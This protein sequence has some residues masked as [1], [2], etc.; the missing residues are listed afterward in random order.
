MNPSLTD[1]VLYHARCPDGFGSAWLYWRRL[2][3]RA[4]YLPQFYGQEPP[5]VANRNVLMIDVSLPRPV[6]EEMARKANTFRLLDH[7]ESAR[8]E[9]ADWPCAHFDLGLSG[10]GLAWRDLNGDAPMPRLAEFIQAR[11]LDK[12]MP[13]G[14]DQVLHVLDSLP[15]DFV[16]WEL[17]ARRVEENLD[18]VVAEGRLMEHR[19]DALAERFLAHATPIQMGGHDGLAVNAPMEFASALGE[20]LC[21]KACFSFTWFMDAQGRIH[22]SWRSRKVNVIPLAQQYGGGG[23]PYAAGARLTVPQLVQAL[24]HGVLQA[25]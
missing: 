7:H 14:G 8:H 24:G 4:V 13:P 20:R 23:H 25:L 15:Y 19:F 9:L 11:D 3:G 21:R 5:D 10:V 1:L 12:P 6:L 17:L 16:A 2:G 22:G 18:A